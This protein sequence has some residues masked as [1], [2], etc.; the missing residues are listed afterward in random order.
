M[1]HLLSPSA[2]FSFF[3]SLLFIVT[4]NTLQRHHHQQQKGTKHPLMQNKKAIKRGQH[5]VTDLDDVGTEPAKDQD[6]HGG[7]V[8]DGGQD[9]PAAAVRGQ[10]DPQQRCRN[11]DHVVLQQDREH[12]RHGRRARALGFVIQPTTDC[13][14]RNDNSALVLMVVLHIHPHR[15]GGK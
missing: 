6:C 15:H 9:E 3:S 7:T 4:P 5:G 8:G 2:G 11:A 12:R 14:C 1:R 10:R 13:S